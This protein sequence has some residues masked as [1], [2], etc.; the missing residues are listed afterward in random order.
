MVG[1]NDNCQL[2]R[3][4]LGTASSYTALC[5]SQPARF[6]SSSVLFVLASSFNALIDIGLLKVV[7]AGTMANDCAAGSSLTSASAGS[8]MASSGC[9]NFLAC[10]LLRS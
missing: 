7:A 4:C 10:H 3:R 5:A 6:L 2:R 1:T 8:V 9:H